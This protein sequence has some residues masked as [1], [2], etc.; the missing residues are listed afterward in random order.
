MTKSYSLK[1]YFRP[2]QSNMKK[3]KLDIKMKL[4]IFKHE[5][6]MNLNQ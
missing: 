5:S 6:N 1:L 4:N 2:R 3:K